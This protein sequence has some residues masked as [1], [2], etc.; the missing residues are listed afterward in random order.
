KNGANTVNAVVTIPVV[1]H[2]VYNS[3]SQNISDAQCQAQLSQLNLDFAKLNS[4]ASAIPAVWQGTAANTNIQFCL[5]QKDPNGIAT[6]GIERRNTVVTSFT[7]D[8]LVKQYSTGGL[9]A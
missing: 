4:D 3:P 6:S 5:A 9:N 7:T 1:F 8:D 2:I